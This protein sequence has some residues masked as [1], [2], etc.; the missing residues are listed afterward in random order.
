MIGNDYLKSAVSQVKILV[1]ILD[2]VPIICTF[3]RRAIF[4]TVL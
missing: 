2:F 1:E 4:S 3:D